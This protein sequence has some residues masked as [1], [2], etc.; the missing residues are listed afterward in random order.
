MNDEPTGT[1]IETGSDGEAWGAQ[2]FPEKT[3]ER[4]GFGGLDESAA[5]GDAGD[6]S[7]AHAATPVDRVELESLRQMLREQEAATQRAVKTAADLEIQ[8]S[9]AKLNAD[10]VG[11]EYHGFA[12]KANTRKQ[13]EL[14]SLQLQWNATQRELAQ[15]KKKQKIEASRA[16]EA[17]EKVS[18][19]EREL[20]AAAASAQ[21]SNGIL[22]RHRKVGRMVATVAGAAAL[23]V[24][25]IVYWPELA[26]SGTGSAHAKA[27][28][29]DD[30]AAAS[31]A[32][33]PGAPVAD[34]ASDPVSGLAEPTAAF[35]MSLNRL[36]DA[37][38]AVPGRSPE[39][40]LREISHKGHGCMFE[41]NN[42]RPA[43]LFGGA[44][45]TP[46]SLSSA[47]DQ[48]ADAVKHL[49]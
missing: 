7:E 14:A 29:I 30:T 10:H 20:E 44:L 13:L 18:S 48:C 28:E 39:E 17:A 24:L 6:K 25:S 45:S 41:W 38:A 31:L 2:D 11:R 16:A 37:L 8:L 33:R 5:K 19:L 32:P 23:I 36:D 21:N 9:S 42:G 49:R 12:K 40:I 1:P 3:D 27:A 34:A 47:I 4:A 43:L 22:L 15:Q 35:T 46:D 26:T